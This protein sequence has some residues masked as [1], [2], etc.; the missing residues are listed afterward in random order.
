[1]LLVTTSERV[2]RETA[3]QVTV[4]KARLTREQLVDGALEYSS[5][6][7]VDD[8]ATAVAISNDYAP[9]H[10]IL[11]VD[12]PRSWLDAVENAGSVFL[13]PWAPESVGDYCSGTNHVLPTYGYARRSSSLGL[14]D[15]MRSMT[16]QELTTEGIAGIGPVAETLARLEGLDAHAEAVRLRLERVRS[17]G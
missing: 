4:Q 8:L 10:L 2:A 14:A 12:Q 5:I 11:Q 16:V 3:S 6:I 7:L 17:A 15:F 1:M 13:G 9:E